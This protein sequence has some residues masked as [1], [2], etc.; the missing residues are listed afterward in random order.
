MRTLLGLYASA[1]F[2]QGNALRLLSPF[3]RTTE[4]P[5]S[6]AVFSFDAAAPKKALLR[7]AMRK[8][9][10]TCL[11]VRKVCCLCEQAHKELFAP[12]FCAFIALTPVGSCPRPCQS[13]GKR[14]KHLIGFM[15]VP[16]LPV[17]VRGVTWGAAPRSLW[18]QAHPSLF[19]HGAGSAAKRTQFSR[20]QPEGSTDTGRRRPFAAACSRASAAVSAVA[21]GAISTD[22]RVH[23]HTAPVLTWFQLKK[24]QRFAVQ[25][26]LR[27][28][29]S[30]AR[31][32]E[33]IVSR[34]P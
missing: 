21:I 7:T 13:A 29:A 31:G 19:R 9:T 15:A 4:E 8:N 6:S 30:A 14:P 18:Q 24:R 27:G 17:E 22:G 12:S 23:P 25:G 20:S 10:S 28:N 5:C 26:L 1:V 34:L 11:R 3:Q 32:S 2:R 16:L 33:A